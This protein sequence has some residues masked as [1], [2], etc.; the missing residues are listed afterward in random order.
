[1]VLRFGFKKVIFRMQDTARCIIGQVGDI[2]HETFPRDAAIFPRNV[3]RNASTRPTM[4]QVIVI[5]SVELR[6]PS[7]LPPIPEV[8]APTAAPSASYL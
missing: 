5:L 4:L 3:P 7:R 1:M 2:I 8:S 6:L